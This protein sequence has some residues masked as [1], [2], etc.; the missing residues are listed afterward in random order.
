MNAAN[1]S[2]HLPNLKHE[3]NQKNKLY[4]DIREWLKSQSVG[5]LSSNKDS[6]GVNLIN[7]LCDALW[8]VDGN[9]S[10]LYTG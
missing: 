6:L 5:F 8:Y 9:H 3:L 10:T 2:C 7:T 1:K 4:N